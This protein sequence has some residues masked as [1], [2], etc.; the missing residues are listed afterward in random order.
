[1][2]ES[3]IGLVLFKA[4]TVFEHGAMSNRYHRPDDRVIVLNDTEFTVIP[5]DKNACTLKFVQLK[6]N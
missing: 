6:V 4:M 1:M 5:V 3:S 2:Q